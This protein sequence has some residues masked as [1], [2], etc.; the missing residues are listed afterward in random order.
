MYNLNKL[1]RNVLITV[2]EVLFHAPTKHTLDPRMIESS[3]IVAEERF[4]RV[5]LGSAMYDYIVDNKNVLVTVGNVGALET[6]SGLDLTVG[7]ILNGYEQL[8][9]SYQALWKQHL[10]KIVAECVI[11]S[12]YPEGFVQMGS[13]GTIHSS[14]PAGLMVTSG[15]VVPLLSSMKWVIDKKIQDRLSPLMNSMH[16]FICK[17]KSAN[18]YDLYLKTCPEVDCAGNVKERQKFTGVVMDIY[19]DVDE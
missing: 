10:W 3:I 17:N 6:V 18:G 1:E 12:A 19:D 2:E 8:N 9:P 5:E 7:Q 4:M 14:P 13:E 15:Q 16:D 11:I